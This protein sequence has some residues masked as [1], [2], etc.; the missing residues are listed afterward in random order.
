MICLFNYSP[1]CWCELSIILIALFIHSYPCLFVLPSRFVIP[2]VEIAF[3]LIL[4]SVLFLT[5][6]FLSLLSCQN[7]MISHFRRFV[8]EE[9]KAS[10]LKDIGELEIK[11]GKLYVCFC[12]Q[13]FFIYHCFANIIFMSVKFKYFLNSLFFF[14][15]INFNNLLLICI[16][17]SF[18]INLQVQDERPIL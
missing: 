4:L 12:F 15:F 6:P 10:W 9:D 5:F 17:F 11:S 13:L 2:L 3:I 7:S 16:I 14:K 1:A 18:K 8:A